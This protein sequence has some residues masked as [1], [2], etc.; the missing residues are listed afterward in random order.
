MPGGAVS[1]L[2]PTSKILVMP[3]PEPSAVPD[4][5]VKIPKAPK[6]RTKP[7]KP[8]ALQRERQR[9][10][11]ALHDTVCQELTGICLM[12]MAAAREHH[13]D[14]PAAEQKFRELAGLIRNAGAGL[15]EFVHALKV[16][17]E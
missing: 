12:A 16:D 13:A 8:S 1:L 4:H 15:T 11:K 10:A 14:C 17:A 9:V 2:A 7:A 5:V 3:T 6:A